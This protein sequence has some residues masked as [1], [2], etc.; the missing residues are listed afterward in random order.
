MRWF[1]RRRTREPK[2][3]KDSLPEETLAHIASA[4]CIAH[5]KSEVSAHQSCWK[6]YVPS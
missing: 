5:R 4:G 3:G 2:I 6:Y 1:E